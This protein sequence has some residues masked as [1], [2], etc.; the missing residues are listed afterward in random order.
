MHKELPRT[1]IE[2]LME[3]VAL[4][5]D[6]Y[7]SAQTASICPNLSD[8]QIVDELQRMARYAY[9]K[10]CAA[11]LALA[12]ERLWHFTVEMDKWQDAIWF[13]YTGKPYSMLNSIAERIYT[14][15]KGR[16]Q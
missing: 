3:D 6:K 9:D 10:E 12:A 5:V 2:T 16:N 1:S 8:S 4:A 7:R 14:K 15:R 13:W 11:F